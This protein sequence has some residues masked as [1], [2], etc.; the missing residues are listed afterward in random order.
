WVRSRPVRRSTALVL[1]LVLA[2]GQAL[3]ACGDDDRVGDER[4]GQ[5]RQ[6][7]LDA[8]LDDEVADVLA[9]A[10]AG[11]TATFQVTYAGTEGA[12]VMVSQQPPNRRIDVLTAGL[13]VQSQVV[14]DGV[15]YLCSLP[16]G[17]Q[18]G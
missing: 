14:R 4:A 17:A 9:L 10:A 15:G 3:A 6:A 5:V 8:G 2:A 13:I 16:E 7:A 11:A 1:A 18:P 12:E